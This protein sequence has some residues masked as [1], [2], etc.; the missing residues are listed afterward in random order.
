MPIVGVVREL[1]LYPL[2]SMAAESLQSATV[3]WHGFAGDR[4]WAFVRP[5]MERSGFPWLTI[6]EKPDLWLHKPWFTD[7]ADVENS[8]TIVRTPDGVELEV[9]DPELSQRLGEGV[10]VIKVYSGVFDTFP[11]S[12]LTVQSVQGLSNLV[13]QTLRTLRFRPNLLIDA[14][15]RDPF[16]EDGWEG[17]VL[18]IGGL[19]CRLDKRD[20]RCMM[21][22]I[23]PADPTS[24]NPAVLRALAKERNAHFGVYGTTVQP[25]EVSV[26]D[27]V[28]LET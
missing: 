17:A 8:K 23:D 9:T 24:T 1:R 5:G 7:S 20:K 3:S 10:R 25:G 6:R 13:G 11:L 14:S 16:P 12:L 26:G 18:R 4:R 15:D 28:V 2:K 27:P 19:R 22:N 21:V